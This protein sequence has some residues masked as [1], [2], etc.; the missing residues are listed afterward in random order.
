[1]DNEQNNG[2]LQPKKVKKKHLALKITAIVLA[3]LML[4]AVLI[5]AAFEIYM[6]V[7][8]NLISY[9]VSSADSGAASD[10]TWSGVN[11]DESGWDDDDSDEPVSDDFSDPEASRDPELSDD[12][13]VP[14]ISGET[15]QGGNTSRPAVSEPAVEA[16][17]SILENLFDDTPYSDQYDSEVINILLIG[18][19][20]K[21]GKS[22]RSDTMILMSINNTKKRIVFTS[23]MRDTYVA[24]TGYK[25]NRLNAAY[26]AGGPKLLM[27]TI[28][29]NFKI[30]I[31]Y[32]VTVNFTSFRN[33]IDGIGGLDMVVN[34]N[35]YDYFSHYFGDKLNG[36]SQAEAIDG[37]HIVHL[38]GDTS[39]AYAR[40]RSLKGSDFT[41]TLH[42]R[43]LI[44]QFVAHCKTL[45]IGEI[46]TLLSEVL[47]WVSTNMPKDMLKMM[48]RNVLTY[49]S[50]SVT[51]MRVP[52]AG[53]FQNATI[54]G[55]AVLT[56][57]FQKNIKYL[58]AKIYG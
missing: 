55:R 44:N 54:S 47:P 38:D 32:Y 19:D 26:A 58:Y 33:A 27:D 9:D 15:S 42:Q 18:A 25:N 23:F 28:E 56:V 11:I 4:L 34:E 20:T 16:D 41:R 7:M 24:I 2:S 8:F 57:D 22:A 50:Y 39:L 52:C 48:V 51:D 3:S 53:S 29:K 43:D 1:M 49:L 37:T 10:E 35:N 30:N 12:T 46:H 45:S 36:L 17:Y 21:S 14:D 13:S 40:N 6:D 31:D 5:Y